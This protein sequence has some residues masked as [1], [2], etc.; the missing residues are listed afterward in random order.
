MIRFTAGTITVDID[1][2]QWGYTA[3]T[4]HLER[5]FGV[6]PVGKLFRQK[7]ELTVR[8]LEVEFFN[9]DTT[10]SSLRELGLYAARTGTRVQFFPD[11]TDL[12][13]FRWIDWPLDVSYRQVVEGKLR[14]EVPLVEQVVG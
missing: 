12:G 10:I 1:T 2:Y 14:M 3:G 5:V 7:L 4:V 6:T 9:A 13:T 8:T 11:T